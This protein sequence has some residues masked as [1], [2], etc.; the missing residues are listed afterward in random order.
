M[1]GLEEASCWNTICLQKQ[2]ALA[3]RGERENRLDF[4][5]LPCPERPIYRELPSLLGGNFSR[6]F[7][8]FSPPALKHL[9]CQGR[10]ASVR[11]AATTN[12]GFRIADQLLSSRVGF[13]VVMTWGDQIPGVR[14]MS[15][16]IDFPAS[17]IPARPSTK[18][19]VRSWAI[20]ET[21]SSNST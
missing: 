21:L 7:F 8:S 18:L 14:A 6:P 13:V 10:P 11:V 17:C 16:T 12:S 15:V 5:R 3:T 4:S 1:A 2:F 9:F 20:S 19:D